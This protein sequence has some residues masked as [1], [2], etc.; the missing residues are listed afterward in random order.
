[1]KTVHFILTVIALLLNAGTFIVHGQW[2]YNGNHIYNTNTG[3]VGIG[4]NTPSTLLYVAKN[5]TEPTITIRNQG[6]FGGAT[7]SMKDD[8]SGADWKFKA[9]LSGGFKIRDQLNSLDVF[10]IDQGSFANAI[11]VKGTGNIG[12]ATATPDPSAL[13]ELS[14]GNQGFQLPRLSQAEIQSI[15][16]PADGLMVYCTTDEKF[17]VF[18]NSANF[19]KDI[20]YGSGTIAPAGMPCG[21][22]ISVN[23]TAG[24]VAPVNKSTIYGTVTNI[25]GEMTKCWITS[26]L[27]S[28]M[29]ATFVGDATEPSA[30]WY[31]QFNRQQ[32]FMHDGTTRTPATP[33]IS[34]INESSDWAP[35]NDPCALELGIGWRIPTNTEWTNVSTAGGWTNWN[36]PWNSALK[37]HAAGYLQSSDGSLTFRGSDASYWSSTQSDNIGSWSPFFNFYNFYMGYSVKPFGNT[38]RCV[39]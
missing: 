28:N 37:M 18:I 32:G 33:W 13:L 9:T 21:T 15:Q 16:G 2:N 5:I 10:V 20:T 23:H 4:T 34:S 14:S 19:W 11:Y 35:G 30:G 8:A 12:I 25:P 38:V 27:G 36:G 6:G 24:A 17:Y 7:F 26:N 39:R 29:Q 3:N 1:M 22:P 31:W